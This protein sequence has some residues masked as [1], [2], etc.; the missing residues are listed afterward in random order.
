MDA[1]YSVSVTATSR[2]VKIKASDALFR[3]RN[4]CV[5]VYRNLPPANW[6]TYNVAHFVICRGSNLWCRGL[7]L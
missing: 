3:Y 6:L 2:Q 7:F 1:S 5:N 4:I